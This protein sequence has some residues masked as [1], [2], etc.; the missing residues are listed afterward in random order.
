MKSI[1]IGRIDCDIIV[2]DPNI[3]RRHATITLVDGQ[4]VYQDTS[5]NGT[6]ING[7]VYQNEKVVVSPGTPIF[8]SNKVPLPWSQI[9]MLLP[10]SPLR[11]QG[12][13]PHAQSNAAETQAHYNVGGYQRAATYE[14]ESIGVGL[15]IL[16]FLIPLLGFIFYFVWK[17][18]EEKKA[19]QAANIAWIR[20]AIDF[21]I[22]F[23]IGLGM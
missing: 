19:K 16:S 5:K 2:S 4:Y 11:A 15:G 23:M 10:D 9:L 7:R 1:T 22:G 21:V 13:R 12:P 18:T 8:L 3:S 14:E 6:T 17:D 20:I